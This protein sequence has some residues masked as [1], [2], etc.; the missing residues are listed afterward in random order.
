MSAGT[1]G[2]EFVVAFLWVSQWKMHLMRGKG[3]VFAEE[4]F[5]VFTL[6]V[7]SYSWFCVQGLDCGLPFSGTESCMKSGHWLKKCYCHLVL[8]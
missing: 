2:P 6:L 7:L 1:P 4:M 5:S 3:S 8:S